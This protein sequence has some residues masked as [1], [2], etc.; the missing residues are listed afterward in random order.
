[1]PM[2]ILINKSS[3]QEDLTKILY[4]HLSGDFMRIAEPI[5]ISLTVTD[6]LGDPEDNKHV[7]AEAFAYLAEAKV[8]I[9]C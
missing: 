4:I 2:I 8:V 6:F 1:M 9:L 5:H 7:Q 3:W